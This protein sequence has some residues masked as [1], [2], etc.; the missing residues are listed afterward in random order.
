[1]FFILTFFLLAIVLSIPLLSTSSDYP[2]VFSN[3]S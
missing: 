3:I 2:L 1:L